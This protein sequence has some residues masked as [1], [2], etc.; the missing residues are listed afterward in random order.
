[1]HCWP[2]AEDVLPAV[3]YLSSPH[4]HMFHYQAEVQVGH[5][6]REVEFHDLL[7]HLRG[8]TPTGDLGR[9]SCEDLAEDMIQVIKKR[10]PGRWCRVSV[11]EDNECGAIVEDNE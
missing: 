11:F 4:R 2:E 8:N 7:N 5:N 6:D 3:G 1:M 10:H 9:L